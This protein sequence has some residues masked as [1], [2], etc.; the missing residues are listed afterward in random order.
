MTK[1]SRPRPRMLAAVLL[2]PLLLLAACGGDSTDDATA[3][4]AANGSTPAATTPGDAPAASGVCPVNSGLRDETITSYATIGEVTGYDDE[5]AKRIGTT[6]RHSVPITLH[7]PLDAPCKIQVGV[8]VT[9]SAGG[10]TEGSV[11]SVLE[12]GASVDVQQFVL[13]DDFTFESDAQDAKPTEDLDIKVSWIATGPVYDYYDAD[14]TVGE[15]TGEGADTVLPVTIVK[16]GMKDGVPKAFGITAT[17]FIYVV[18][19][20]ASG[21]TVATFYAADAKFVYSGETGTHNIPATFAG[22]PNGGGMAFQGLAALED[23]AEY[24]VVTYQPN[25]MQHEG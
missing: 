9:G 20:D 5:T 10:Y 22:T 21:K 18:G 23:I 11:V 24:K 1:L 4:P 19:H 15:P 2:A 6:W 13:E 7:N 16:R 17:D 25:S 8:T 14:V 12:P 3:P